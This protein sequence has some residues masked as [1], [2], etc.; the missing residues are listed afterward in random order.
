M[1]LNKG[2][3]KNISST[4]NSAREQLESLKKV[5]RINNSE[6]EQLNKFYIF[7]N[8]KIKEQQMIITLTKKNIYF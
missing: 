3:L 4:K 8:F 1:A 7:A 6:E 5:H 2:S